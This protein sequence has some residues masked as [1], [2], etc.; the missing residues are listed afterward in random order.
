MEIS[1]CGPRSS[2]TMLTMTRTIV[3]SESWMSNNERRLGDWTCPN[4]R[5]NVYANR[6]ECFKCRT[7]KP[8]MCSITSD[9]CGTAIS[10]EMRV[11]DWRCPNCKQ[12]VFASKSICFRCK[13]PK[14]QIS[15][16]ITVGTAAQ[17]EAVA[18]L[19]GTSSQSKSK[20]ANITQGSTSADSLR[21]AFS[22]CKTDPG[23][24]NEVS[25]SPLSSQFA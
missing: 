18:H 14:P 7:I 5:Q 16:A 21:S 9:S 11:G 10:N 24:I 4:C 17:S 2:G 19:Q 15:T 25:F 23:H 12:I 1:R 13:S 3:S 22:K 6:S 20:I 8:A